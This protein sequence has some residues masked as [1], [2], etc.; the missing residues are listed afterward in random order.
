MRRRLALGPGLTWYT[1]GEAPWPVDVQVRVEDGPEAAE[2]QAADTADGGG[3][4]GSVVRPVGVL[5]RDRQ[6]AQAARTVPNLDGGT[7]GEALERSDVGGAVPLLTVSA[8]RTVGGGVTLDAWYVSTRRSKSWAADLHSADE[9]WQGGSLGTALRLD[10]TDWTWQATLQPGGVPVA[11]YSDGRDATSLARWTPEPGP[12]WLWL[13]VGDPRESSLVEPPLVKLENRGGVIEAVS[14]PLPAIAFPLLREDPAPPPRLDDLTVA[15]G[16]GSDDL[17]VVR[18]GALSWVPSVGA[19]A[20][21]GQPAG[22]WR[23]VTVDDAVLWRLPQGLPL[24]EPP[25]G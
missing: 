9:M 13:A 22:G 23:Q 18:Q 11:H 21:L 16:R 20:A 4:R 12:V 17:F 3:R 10:G 8:D 15:K 1:T 7:R 24:P 5:V 19:L 2:S 25:A 14:V 6:P